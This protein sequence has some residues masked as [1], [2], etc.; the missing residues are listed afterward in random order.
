MYDI[1]KE[2]A[3]EIGKKL[4]TEVVIENLRGYTH[5]NISAYISTR[6]KNAL[7]SLNPSTKCLVD[8]LCWLEFD[9]VI[10]HTAKNCQEI[11]L[12]LISEDDSVV[13][14]IEPTN[15]QRKPS[16]NAIQLLGTVIGNDCLAGAIL[17]YAVDCRVV[18]YPTSGHLYTG[19]E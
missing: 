15:S 10:L 9:Q 11:G 16:I 12:S 13:F 8:Q 5:V 17:Q 3:D 6:G 14:N 4:K 19:R 18:Y 2:V 7:S 1:W